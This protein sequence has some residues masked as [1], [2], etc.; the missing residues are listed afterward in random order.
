MNRIDRLKSLLERDPTDAFLH[1]GLAMEY[2]KLGRLDD[3]LAAF[4]R[5]LE[6][7]PNYSAAYYHKGNTLIGLGR[8]E[9]ARD[10]LA[11]GV[12]V[13]RRNGDPHAQREM[14]ELLASLG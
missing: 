6:H 12:E 10:V 4:D 14:E 11:R 7:D 9:E 1:F 2:V 8:H 3:A 5:V 13:T